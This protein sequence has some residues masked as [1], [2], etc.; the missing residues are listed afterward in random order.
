MDVEEHKWECAGEREERGK[1]KL[2]SVCKR[3]N[4]NVNKIK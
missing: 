3:N 2:Y 4:K 1:G